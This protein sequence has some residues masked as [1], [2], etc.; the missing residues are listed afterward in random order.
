MA[1]VVD[2]HIIRQ[3]RL[4]DRFPLLAVDSKRAGIPTDFGCLTVSLKA[5]AVIEIAGGLVPVVLNDMAE[6]LDHRLEQIRLASTVPADKN[7]DE[8]VTVE[9][10]REVPEVLVLADVNRCQAH[11]I[12]LISAPSWH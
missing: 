11:G 2:Q 1:G 10:Q 8:A 3:Q 5:D 9:A 7:I 6:D 12:F 4:S